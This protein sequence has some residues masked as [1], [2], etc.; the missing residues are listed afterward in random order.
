MKNSQSF[1]FRSKLLMSLAISIAFWNFGFKMQRCIAQAHSPPVP[2]E[3]CDRAYL[4]SVAHV[5]TFPPLNSGMPYDVM[6]GYIDMDSVC[7][8]ATANQIDS[9][10]SV[11]TYSDTSR[12]ALKYLY[13]VDDYNPLLYYS[14]KYTYAGKNHYNNDAPNYLNDVFLSYVSHSFPDSGRASTLAT[15]DMILHILVIDTESHTDTNSLL[16]RQ[17]IRVDYVV[18]DTIKGQV[19]PL[20]HWN[21]F[22]NIKQK[23]VTDYENAGSFEYSPQ[24]GRLPGLGDDII[25]GRGNLVWFD[26]TPWIKAGGEYIVFLRIQQIWDGDSDSYYTVWPFAGCSKM[27]SMYPITNGIV[28]DRYND[29]GLGPTPTVQNFMDGLRARIYSITHP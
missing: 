27:G 2:C 26:G 14:W 22:Q 25:G 8:T 4:D 6:I 3:S 17:S 15:A 16:A 24:W 1:K 20:H 7:R 21:G 29:W 18:L 9:V 19:L 10:Y 5:T 23:H 28:D 11:A 12:Y 13:E